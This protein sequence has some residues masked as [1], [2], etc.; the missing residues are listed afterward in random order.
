MVLNKPCATAAVVEE[1]AE[2]LG[3]FLSPAVASEFDEELRSELQDLATLLAPG[4]ERSASRLEA[5]L[6]EPAVGALTAQLR[7]SPQHGE[8]ILAG[9]RAALA[10]WEVSAQLVSRA[11]AMRSRG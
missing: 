7:R 9:A 11:E 1:L 5:L 2:G 8:A 6:K 4:E 3:T 10:H